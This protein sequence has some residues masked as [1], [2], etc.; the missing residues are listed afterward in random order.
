MRKTPDWA[1]A[2]C[3]PEH[4]NRPQSQYLLGLCSL[5]IP[6]RWFL[7]FF[8]LVFPLRPRYLQPYGTVYCDRPCDA[9][10]IIVHLKCILSGRPPNLFGD[11]LL[12]RPCFYP[13]STL[14]S[15][16]PNVGLKSVGK[17]RRAC[18]LV[19]LPRIP[20]LAL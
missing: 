19:V 16:V 13:A 10:Y 6:R 2:S 7:L 12:N 18:S 5:R 15:R 8:F 17:I 14:L 20:S 3:L 1:D 11:I 4:F 9:S